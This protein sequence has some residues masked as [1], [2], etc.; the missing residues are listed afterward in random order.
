MNPPRGL[1]L[2]FGGN[3][4]LCSLCQKATNKV[5][6]KY[7]FE[8]PNQNGGNMKKF[9]I[10]VSCLGICLA[11]CNTDSW[12]AV[13]VQG[14]NTNW[15]YIGSVKSGTLIKIAASGTVDFG[16]KWP[17]S[18]VDD[19]KAGVVGQEV[20]TP[21]GGNEY[22]W[23]MLMAKDDG[24]SA[25]LD[26]EI[27]KRDPSNMNPQKA[28]DILNLY[29][30]NLYGQTRQPNYIQGGVWIKINTKKM[31]PYIAT[32][33][34]YFWDRDLNKHGLP[35]TE[36]VD[37]YAKAHDGGMS[38]DS[39][40]DYGDNKGSYRVEIQR[41]ATYY[42]AGSVA[43]IPP[44][45]TLVQLKGNPVVFVIQNGKKCG[46]PG[47]DVFEAYGYRWDDVREIDQTAFN[48]IPAGPVIPPFS[49]NL[50]DGTLIQ[51][52]GGQPAAYVIQNGK[53]CYIPDPTTFEA[54]GYQWNNIRQI[55]QATF[56][57]IPTGPALPSVT[58]IPLDGT[59]IQLKGHPEVYVILNGKKC[60]IPNPAT[61]DAR[62]YH[63]DKIK[64]IDQTAFN[65]IP[66][67]SPLPSVQ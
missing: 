47:W 32:Q 24:M 64:Q 46:I 12:A 50:P 6:I 44:D 15:T 52:K 33:L 34:Y 11:I 4:L 39:T 14:N 21:S 23:A 43:G 18:C 17:N 5:V 65:K 38:P 37:V 26:A 67:G 3:F 22:T 45:G 54:R 13:N 49:G 20:K 27:R 9:M 25:L 55:D 28:L 66:M 59:L 53:K 51:L 7:V 19:A 62:G 29:K 63:W 41:G 8:L 2:S 48:K 35:I 16:C 1:P 58:V 36:D 31:T 61:F 60:W 30:N 57:A 10:L 42:I 56:N 40:K